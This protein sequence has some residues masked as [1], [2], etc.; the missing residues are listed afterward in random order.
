MHNAPGPIWER[1]DRRG[2]LESLALSLLP[3]QQSKEEANKAAEKNHK[4]ETKKIS[5][6]VTC[7]QSEGGEKTRTH[8]N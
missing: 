4:T 1:G 6:K 2:F 5:G 7:R 3:T 8:T